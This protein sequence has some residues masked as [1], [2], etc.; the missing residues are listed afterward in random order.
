[1]TYQ[2]H[3]K[4]LKKI[5]LIHFK[6]KNTFKKYLKAKLEAMLNNIVVVV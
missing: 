1:L 2:N 4:I 5:N 3:H 6:A